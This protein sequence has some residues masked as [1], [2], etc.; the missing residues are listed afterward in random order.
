[1]KRLKSPENQYL[2]LMERII[3]EGIDVKNERTGIVCRTVINADLEYSDF[4]LITT[5]KSFFK[6]AIAEILGYLRG[7]NSA[8]QFRDLGCNTWNAN[9]NENK[10][11]LN[12]PNRQGVDDMGK[13]YRFRDLEYGVIGSDG[14]SVEFINIDQ[15]KKIINNLSKGIDDRGEIMTAW[16]PHLEEF[17]CL[18]SCMHTHT[19]SLLGD[20]LHQTSYQRSC[21]V[22]L[23]LNFNMVQC[24]VLLNL[25]AQI[26]GHKAGKVF[27]KIVNAHIYENQL[28]LAKEQIQREPFTP[29]KLWIN[30]D[31]KTLEDLETWVTT[32]DFA[33]IGE[34]EHH[35]AIKYP[36]AV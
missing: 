11:W 14:D 3:D 20:T 22:P 13:A 7:Y 36:F 6:A 32:D 35:E 31:I 28:E 1:M 26:T 18:R 12:N 34:Y 4:P 27:H 30:P 21:D 23:G 24:H 15:F 9:A 5:R 25:V 2:D 29:P 8:K 33:L 16:H 10:A 19:F 17:S